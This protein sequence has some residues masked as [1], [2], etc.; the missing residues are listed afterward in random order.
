MQEYR[1]K[2]TIFYKLVQLLA[3]AD[4]MDLIARTHAAVKEA[5]ISL[6]RV[7]GE[8]GLK[9]NEEKK[10]YLTTRVDKNKNQPKHLQIGNLKFER[11][12]SITYLGSL[13]NANDNSAEIKKRILWANKSFYGLRGQFRSVLIYKKQN[14]RP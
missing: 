3:Y 14:I 6:E 10:K 4:N 7:A 11:V 13:I 9:I 5:C 8:M 1:Q 12:Q 2:G